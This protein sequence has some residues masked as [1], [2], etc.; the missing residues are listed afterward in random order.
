MGVDNMPVAKYQIGL[1]RIEV[2]ADLGKCKKIYGD[3]FGLADNV[4][5]L[6]SMKKDIANASLGVNI[7]GV[8]VNGSV[9]EVAYKE[10]K[11]KPVVPKAIRET[12]K[13]VDLP[14]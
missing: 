6:N 12:L 1:E 7:K 14:D 13:L 11:G 5:I 8:Q 4:I 10:G 3:S 9:L 2:Y